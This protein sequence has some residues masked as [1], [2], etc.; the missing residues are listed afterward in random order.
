MNPVSSNNPTAAQVGSTQ[1]L[2]PSADPTREIY[3]ELKILVSEDP[4]LTDKEYEDWIK[5]NPF[6]KKYEVQPKELFSAWERLVYK[7]L[8]VRNSKTFS[9]QEI[10]ALLNYTDSSISGPKEEDKP[11]FN[12]FIARTVLDHLAKRESTALDSKILNS[13]RGYARIILFRNLPLGHSPD[14]VRSIVDCLREE[15]KAL[16]GHLGK[17]IT[18]TLFDYYLKRNDQEEILI[19]STELIN[20]CD[21]KDKRLLMLAHRARAIAYWD[22]KTSSEDLKR[23]SLGLK[24]LE[25]AEA[26]SAEIGSFSDIFDLECLALKRDVSKGLL[27]DSINKIET[28]FSYYSEHSDKIKYAKAV[29]GLSFLANLAP[30]IALKSKEGEVLAPKLC[31]K[32]LELTEGHYSLD[33]LQVLNCL[34]R[35]FRCLRDSRSNQLVFNQLKEE[36]GILIKEASHLEFIVNLYLFEGALN[37]EYANTAENLYKKL[38]TTEDW[39]SLSYEFKAQYLM[40]LGV[41]CLNEDDYV[42]C[43]KYCEESIAILDGNKLESEEALKLAKDCLSWLVSGAEKLTSAAK[44]I[45]DE[46]SQRVKDLKVKQKVYAKA[47]QKVRSL[48]LGEVLIFNN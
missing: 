7:L 16:G 11:K 5:D 17:V 47:F 36:S 12:S 26:F 48:E 2:E 41:V 19:E 24:N 46:D 31:G 15:R 29:Q 1:D 4:I 14:E 21:K 34:T 25:K 22:G 18:R 43:F 9:S 8:Q 6:V 28:L 10:T 3:K 23:D 33:R 20:H 39:K 30:D 35:V 37:C 13:L 32:Y 45:G 27:A 38:S 44:V 40:D 42:A